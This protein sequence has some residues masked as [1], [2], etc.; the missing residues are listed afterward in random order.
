[1]QTFPLF[2]NLTGR[3]VLVIGGGTVA[4]R[5]AHALLDAGARYTWPPR[6]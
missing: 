4:E 2:A 1:M 6:S 3:P 5:K